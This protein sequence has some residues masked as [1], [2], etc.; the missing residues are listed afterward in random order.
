[1]QFKYGLDDKPPLGENLLLGVQWL[2]IAIPSIM[3]IGKIVGG[4]HFPNL[5]D[6]V[7]YLQKLSF[8]M[9]V[10]LFF[11]ILLGH[12]LPLIAGP[13]TVLLI[14]I[15]TS[16]G[17]DTETIY[18]TMMLGGLI[19]A[20]VSATGLFGHLQ[21]LF[22]PR[23]IAVV[24]L[25]IGFTLMPTV[26]NLISSPVG[27][28]TSLTH[29]VFSFCLILGMIVFQKNTK[30]IWK[31]TLIVWAILFGSMVYHLLFPEG[32]S[33]QKGG[34]LAPLAF[35][36]KHLTIHFSIDP[37]VFISFLFC[38][39][40]LSINDLGSI[41]SLDDLLKPPGMAHRINRGLTFTGMANV[42]AG[43]FGVVGPVNFSLS[44]GVILSTG[45]ASRYTLIPTALILF[46]LSFSPALMGLIGMVPPVVIGSVLAYIL[47][48]QVMAGL[49]LLFKSEGPFQVETGLI[50][51]LP[52][53]LGI[54][55][56][57]LPAGVIDT[58]PA[59]LRPVMGNGFVIG[60]FIAF[61]L[62]H[63]VFRQKR[64]T[65]NPRPRKESR[66]LLK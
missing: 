10:T 21:R 3:I 38:F 40:A 62:E 32:L 23:V 54:I 30:G 39:L 52:I 56:A 26:M 34:D 16:R 65:S 24:L 61:F 25:L 50:V 53:L 41:E 14:G 2:F 55:V 18:F 48:F 59:T 63:L 64:K 28:V 15:I 49:F 45:C 35:F 20:L 27:T 5:P 46:L 58:F 9:A 19:L 51:G 12:G 36:F 4:F 17:V 57:F 1:M 29:M 43:F 33:V 66:S 42:L 6:Q 7:I 47:C 37:G 44:P 13:S 31:S 60:T 11:Q 22:T 8:V